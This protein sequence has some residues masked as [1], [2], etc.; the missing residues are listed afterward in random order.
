[1]LFVDRLLE[2]NGVLVCNKTPVAINQMFAANEP[3]AAPMYIV[4]LRQAS[5]VGAG[6]GSR[7]QVNGGSKMTSITTTSTLPKD[8]RK[9]VSDVSAGIDAVQREHDVIRQQLRK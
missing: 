8:S 5:P 1:M 4:L 9:A 6:G 3:Y 2:V 7:V